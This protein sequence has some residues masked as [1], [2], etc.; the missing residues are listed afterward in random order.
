MFSKMQEAL[1][2]IKEKIVTLH[3]G[4][5]EALADFRWLAEDVTKRPTCIYELFLLIFTVD[6]YHDAS[7][8]M[9]GGMVLPGPTA[10]TRVW[11]PQPSAAHPPP[12]PTAAHPVVCKAPLPKEDVDSLIS[13]TNPQGTVKNSELEQA[14][15]IIHSDC[16][17]QFFVVTKRT[18][19]YRTDNTAGIW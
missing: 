17:A 9:C 14:G 7:G 13:R 19:L 11:M 3:K 2:H 12:N 4:V 5:H 18:V 1:C 8:Y 10:M 15:G 16:V 6:G